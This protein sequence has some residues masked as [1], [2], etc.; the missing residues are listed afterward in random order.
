MSEKKRNAK[1]EGSFTLNADGTVTHRKSVGFKPNGRRKVF[2]VTAKTKSA[3]IKEMKKKE[4]EWNKLKNNGQIHYNETITNLCRKHLE[5][6]ISNKDLKGKSIDR[7][8]CTIE[9]QIEGYDLGYLQVYTVTPTDIEVH[10]NKLIAEGKV[11]ESSICKVVDVL[12][13]AYEW[14]IRQGDLE[15]NPVRSIKPELIKKI[16]KLSCKGANEADVAVLSDEEMKLFEQEAT[17]T[18][19]NGKMKYTA[20]FYCLLLLHTGMRVGEMIALRWRDWKGAHLIIEKSISMAKNRSKISDEDNNYISLEGST[21]NQKARTIELTKEAQYI[22]QK[23]KE[24]RDS[25]EPNQ[26]IVTTKT[27]KINTASNLEHRMKVILKNAELQDVSGGLHIFR[28]TFATRMYESG[29]RVEEIA[30]YIGDLESTTQKYYIAI[31][32][33]V[34]S[35]GEVRQVVKLPRVK[36]ESTVA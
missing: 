6:Q 12:N 26:F 24:N 36:E 9:N 11:G 13:A 5:Y 22:L 2:T 33:K 14:A 23:I 3:C 28:K 15:K 29:A 8:E 21:K 27:G 35:N 17:A 32:K 31:R 19:K 7:R 20:G 30:A 1:G 16:K 34:I 18:L 10:V 25:S 4:S